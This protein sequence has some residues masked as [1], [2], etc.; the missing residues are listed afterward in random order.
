M[1]RL[2]RWPGVVLSLCLLAAAAA[3]QGREHDESTAFST[4][5]QQGTAEGWEEFLRAHPS[6][7]H[8]AEA[9]RELD[10]A[11]VRLADA[12][13]DDADALGQLYKRCR[14]PK[15]ADQVFAK[16]DEA[17]FA[18]AVQ[19]DDAA[20]F[21]RYLL[22]FPGG[23]HVAEAK[24]RI[25]DR[26]WRDCQASDTAKAYAGYLRD[27]PRGRHATEARRQQERLEFAELEQSGGIQ[28]LQK[29]LRT[30]PS[31][32]AARSR[33]GKLL[34]ERAVESGT[35]AD[36][37][38]FVDGYATRWRRS[39]HKAERQM[40]EN[41]RQELERALFE[42]LLRAPTRALCDAYLRRY[43]TGARRDQVRVK[44]E[45]CLFAEAE[46]ANRTAGYLEYLRAYPRGYRD[47]LVR[48][49]LESLLF[50]E[51]SDKETFR[52]HHAYLR[53]A[54]D[55]AGRVR[56][57]LE[58]I[59]RT[60]A[61]KVNTTTAFETYLKDFAAHQDAGAVKRAYDPL[62]FAAAK[63]KDWH[64]DYK[65]YLKRMPDG[66]HAAAAKQRLEFLTTNRAVVV[67]DVPDSVTT[68][69]GGRWSW[70]T[71]F[72][73]TGGKVGFRLSGYGWVIDP[74]GRR[75][76]PSGHRVSRGTVT[77]RPGGTASD[78]YWCRGAT[79]RGGSVT[80]TWSGEDAGGHKL[81]L[82]ERVRLN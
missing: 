54:G 42:E 74:K 81:T 76:G 44:H 9:R 4:A 5:K 32:D 69:T 11:L 13:K 47:A 46:R 77:V 35:A 38:A 34:Y 63:K 71:K 45:E 20:A 10:A 40:L 29:F 27:H 72:K 21:R 36:W 67:L 65:N 26:A 66:A 2:A 51:A 62:L 50:R 68:S 8:A 64:T 49:R 58:P 73:E 57:R 59:V 37:R 75:W 43:P 3:A 18:T 33:L 6:G 28:A 22:R 61:L 12:R 52:D 14:T 53:L 31:H 55:D 15:V 78:S 17:S 24:Q 25:D 80:V 82:T 23:K 1:T 16:W 19:K 70:V 39:K 60:W 79:F 7:A 56:E 30:H 41:S 48:V